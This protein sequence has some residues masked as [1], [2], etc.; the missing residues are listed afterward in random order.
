MK[1]RIA[2]EAKGLVRTYTGRMTGLSRTHVTRLIRSFV[3]KREVKQKPFRRN[4]FP[5]RYTRANIELL[6]EAKA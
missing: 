5:S 3:R 6:A 4:R 1:G 2:R